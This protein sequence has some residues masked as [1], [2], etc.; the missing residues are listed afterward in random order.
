MQTKTLNTG[1]VLVVAKQNRSER[2]SLGFNDPCT[3]Y[4]Y[5]DSS[6]GVFDHRS[7]PLPPGQW[8][9]LG[10][11]SEIEWEKWEQIVDTRQVMPTISFRRGGTVYYDYEKPDHSYTLPDESGLSL[12]RSLGHEPENCIV[13]FESKK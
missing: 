8:Q 10:I 6:H 4:Y 9:L 13:L 2:F 3:L 5:Y 7:I 12:L 1:R 11:G